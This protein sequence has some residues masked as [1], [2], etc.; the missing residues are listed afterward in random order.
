MEPGRLFRRRRILR[1]G[2][3][4]LNPLEAQKGRRLR[5]LSILKLAALA[6]MS[7]AMGAPSS[8]AYP[9][10]Y[11]GSRIMG[12]GG[13]CAVFSECPERVSD[14]F[15][16]THYYVD[17]YTNDYLRSAYL[18]FGV[19]GEW[20]HALGT[21]KKKRPRRDIAL[22]AGTFYTTTEFQSLNDPQVRIA[23]R[24]FSTPKGI[25]VFDV[26]VSNQ[27]KSEKEVRIQ[28]V[29]KFWIPAEFVHAGPP[30]EPVM[31]V[32]GFKG[33]RLG[34]AFDSGR[35]SVEL[36]ATPD[37]FPEL[38]RKLNIPPGQSQNVRFAV[39][40]RVQDT[41]TVPLFRD[42]TLESCREDWNRWLSSGTRPP[43][44]N[45]SLRSAYEASMIALAA[46]SLKG[47]VPAD[48]TGQF[49][50]DGR[51]QLYPR[52]A[53]MT[54]RA[55]AEAGHA[56]LAVEIF[57]FWND[58]I[59][60]KSKGEWYAR[61]DAFKRATPGGSGAAYDV[62]EWDS[63]GYYASL[64]LLLFQK[65]GRWVGDVNLM[66]QMLD[67]VVTRQD[68]SGLL[69]EGGIVE[70]EGF[71]PATNMNVAA[72]LRH[73]A[74]ICE[75]RGEPEAAARYRRAA[76]SIEDGLGRMFSR[77]RGAYMDLRDNREQFNTS[78]NFGYVWGFPDHLEL[79]ATNAWYRQHA[80]RLGAGVQYF[81]AEGY[82]SD[83]FGFTT[84]AAA[85]YH[86]VAGE[87]EFA[88]DH[89]RWLMEHSNVY[90][91]MPERIFFPDGK[92]VSPA[93]PLSW[94][95]AEF[96]VAALE[97]ARVGDPIAGSDSEYV[98]KSFAADLVE[99][100]KIMEALP[101]LGASGRDIRAAV[102]SAVSA[103]EAAGPVDARTK[104]VRAALDRMTGLIE[105]GKRKHPCLVD[106]SFLAARLDDICNRI[107]ANLSKADIRVLV[108]DPVVP[109]GRPV[110]M[111]VE[112]KSGN[113]LAWKQME[114]EGRDGNITPFRQT[115]EAH[116]GV[117]AKALLRVSFEEGEPPYE[118]ALRVSADGEWK[119]IPFRMT[120]TALIRIID[121]FEIKTTES[122]G[123]VRL[124]VKS[125][126]K[127]PGIRI[128]VDA[129]KGWTSH[130]VLSAG[131]AA[132]RWEFDL[133]SSPEVL[134][135]FYTFRLTAA[136]PVKEHRNVR[137]PYRT[138]IDLQG[139][140]EF[141]TGDDSGGASPG[142]PSDGWTRMDVPKTWEDGGFAGYDGT[143][144]YRKET[145][146]P[147]SWQGHDVELV[148]GG[149][150]DQDWTF[151]NGKLI[152]HSTVWNS[153]RRY[154]IP[155]GMV[156][157][158]RTHLIAVRVLDLAF[159]GGIWKLPVR[160]EMLP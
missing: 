51:P 91:M 140:W 146:I 112:L 156:L 139:P 11:P 49:L 159:G 78:S 26:S 103:A 101:Q 46:T 56:N 55:L 105:R 30:E 1:V 96:A 44:E 100:Q 89:V 34:I 39:F 70:W 160:L 83:L 138:T 109:L 33:V 77:S 118:S 10:P 17:D 108:A 133:V 119:G 28:S 115:V 57:Q 150:D 75:M 82:G 6:W 40:P 94:C 143:A 15:G 29:V 129:P 5:E 16:I 38:S 37:A 155:R 141:R 85:Q 125:N 131:A 99:F 152:G 76:E 148:I 50:T 149:V 117:S 132:D 145:T 69:K 53:L 22:S 27:G 32:A 43:F 24:V 80:I 54:A 86:F 7:L 61:Y 102:D 147:K 93:S 134:P 104:T 126:L 74:L 68:R 41:G 87:P 79:A 52:D 130:P 106:I 113:H 64:M 88:R 20:E 65:T 98:L 3:P 154:R 25:I 151:W 128:A 47:A 45:S 67:F 8:L 9:G 81:E 111:N 19:G 58:R 120:R 122:A 107:V 31:A 12:G 42:L 110:E 48:M 63:N 135:G 13:V 18:K 4:V 73:G 116:A 71:L 158:G 123:G 121:R 90:G 136:G 153:E 142:A 92:D 36:G 144:W 23:Y 35:T 95:N 62:P 72:G 21:M 66:K 60:Q 14:D 127:M 59:P 114:L 97:A 2:P 84:A 137:L 157:A 124:T